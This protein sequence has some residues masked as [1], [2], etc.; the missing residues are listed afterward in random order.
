MV[1]ETPPPNKPTARYDFISSNSLKNVPPAN[2][3][4]STRKLWYTVTPYVADAYLWKKMKEEK[5]GE[6]EEEEGGYKFNASL[7]LQ[8]AS[9]ATSA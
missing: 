2:I 9:T 5:G 3:V 8:F 1:R 4:V 7:P 6:R